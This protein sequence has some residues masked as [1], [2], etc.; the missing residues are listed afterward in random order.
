MHSHAIAV[1][2][3]GWYSIRAVDLYSLAVCCA[4]ISIF[5][6]DMQ[7]WGLSIPQGFIEE[8]CIFALVMVEG[9]Q[10]AIAYAAAMAHSAEVEHTI[11]PDTP[12]EVCIQAA[13]IALMEAGLPA[14]GDTVLACGVAGKD[15]IIE[16]LCAG[17]AIAYS[18]A[19]VAP[20]GTKG[21]LP[22]VKVFDS[23]LIPADRLLPYDK[24]GD[25]VYIAI[26]IAAGNGWA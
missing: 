16:T 12:K 22:E 24:V 23:A 26:L 14:L 6:D 9:H 10:A 8:V 18:L 13:D 11:E 5:A 7:G 21:I 2:C 19:E 3:K 4:D 1:D 15:I 20:A 17:L 25:K